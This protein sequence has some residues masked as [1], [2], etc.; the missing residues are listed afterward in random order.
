VISRPELPALLLTARLFA[1]AALLS[2]LIT[3]RAG[4]LTAL[5]LT[6]PP[7]GALT[8]RLLASLTALL[9]AILLHGSGSFVN[10]RFDTRRYSSLTQCPCHGMSGL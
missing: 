6:T 2:L 1:L 3:L 5:F 9:P 4:A 7:P 10:R 8:A